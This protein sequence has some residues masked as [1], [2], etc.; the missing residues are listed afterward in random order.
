MSARAVRNAPEQPVLAYRVAT[1]DSLFAS[2][3]R[4]A[5]APAIPNTDV[6]NALH[7]LP[8][9]PEDGFVPA[10]F[11][12]WAVV[13]DVLTFYQE[14]IAN[15]GYLRTATEALSQRELVRMLSREPRPALSAT[16]VFAFSVA[17]AKGAPAETLVPA[18]TPIGA[19]PPPD[20]S[21]PPVFETHEALVA[22]GEWNA[23][24]PAFPPP[25][26]PALAGAGDAMRLAGDDLSV[27]KPGAPMIVRRRLASGDVDD[28]VVTVI[29]VV[30]D[31]VTKSAFVRWSPV[32]WSPPLEPTDAL[33]FVAFRTS[34]ALFGAKAPEWADLVP[35]IKARYFTPPGGVA[36]SPDGTAW[37]PAGSGAPKADVLALRIAG[38]RLYALTTAA[39]LRADGDAWT[40]LN[41]KARGDLSALAL[42]GD[43]IYAGS[44]R[45]EV[46]VSHDGGASWA[47]VAPAAATATAAALPAVKVHAL[48]VQ[49]PPGLVPVVFAATDRGVAAARDDGKGWSYFNAG[50]GGVTDDKATAPVAIT[51]IALRGTTLLVATSGALWTRDLATSG[52]GAGLPGPA[53]WTAR[54]VSGIPAGTTFAA[55]GF[56]DVYAFAATS[57]GLFRAGPDW[58]WSRVTDAAV[59]AA[60]SAVDAAGASVITTAAGGVAISRDRGTG[61]QTVAANPPVPATAVALA[62]DAQD[63]AYAVPLA[64]FPPD[65]PDMPLGGTGVDVERLVPSLATDAQV[66]LIDTAPATPVAQAARIVSAQTVRRKNFLQSGLVT[67]LELTALDPSAPLASF[68]RRTTRLY[69]DA[70]VL[71]AAPDPV[72]A[73]QPVLGATLTVDAATTPL[74]AGRLVAVYG[75]PIRAHVVGLAGGIRRIDATGAGTAWGLRGLDCRALAAAPDGTVYAGTSQ[76]VWRRPE[77]GDFA[78]WGFDAPPGP[79]PAMRAVAASAQVVVAAAAG[80][81]AGGSIY[82]R[83]TAGGDWSGPA[84]P[85][86]VAALLLGSDGTFWAGGAEGLSRS[87]DG[88][89]WRPVTEPGAPGRGDDGVQSL[90]WAPDG[91]TLLAGTTNGVAVRSADGTWAR[92]LRGLDNRDVTALAA[93]P[94][95]WWAGTNGG[96]VYTSADGGASWSPVP[97]AIQPGLHAVRALAFD[98]VLFAAVRGYGVLRDGVRVDAGIGND[99]RGLLVR[100]DGV[101]AAV[102]SGTVLASSAFVAQTISLRDLGAVEIGYTVDLE[103]GAIPAGLRSD[104]ATQLQLKLPA[105]ATVRTAG[106]GAWLLSADGA[107][108]LLLREAPAR[109]KIIVASVRSFVV[110][111]PAVPQPDGTAMWTVQH[112]DGTATFAARDGDVAYVAAGAADAFAGETVTV[113]STA[114]RR[115]TGIVEITF[116]QPLARVYDGATVQLFGN[117]ATGSHGMSG[118]TYEAIGNG[119]ASQANQAFTL[120]RRSLTMLEAADGTPQPQIAVVVRASIPR[121]A[122]ASA[123]DLRRDDTEAAGVPWTY[124][125]TLA[126]AGPGDRAYSVRFDDDVATVVFGDGTNGSRLPTGN[127]NVVAGYRTGNGPAGN[128]PADS[129]L[130]LRKR[131]GGLN[132]VRNPVDAAGGLAAE[133]PSD[134]VATAHAGLRTLE[135]I[136][137]LSDLEDFAVARTGIAQAKLR[138]A[139]GRRARAYL[140]IA[141][142]D[143]A[144]VADAAKQALLLAI[145]GAGGGAMPVVLHD[146]RRRYVRIAAALRID[147]GLDAAAI[148]AAADARVRDALAFESRALG[149]GLVAARVI[150][151][152]Q[153][154]PGVVAVTLSAFHD[155]AWSAFVAP[156]IAG[157]DAA[158]ASDGELLVLLD[159]DPSTLD[160]TVES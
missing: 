27:L 123:G 120:A 34:A 8:M 59:A 10:L 45:G 159:P 82:R 143:G 121:S 156:V 61:W 135:R 110:A 91:R 66:A 144:A 79:E 9:T 44:A 22:R 30:P 62:A 69:Y 83:A 103:R 94:S 88:A 60:P 102:R 56:G 29:D 139:G 67:H 141:G 90:A 12:A 51:G 20:G 38:G 47:A 149:E 32:R 157:E 64:D 19:S 1:Y 116:A 98:G 5:G 118:S 80:A 158:S 16:C 24:S 133:P 130:M 4:L 92:S 21:P 124:F 89:V 58:A 148:L 85:N 74:P 78:P 111:A 31:A 134:A 153:D 125:E 97:L 25:P 73:L 136:V 33:Q 147:A 71:G 122:I 128:I 76:G 127:E 104:L 49:A 87:A 54:P 106:A 13:G 93:G 108:D 152:L 140:T 53:P 114:V 11:D 50:L 145:R 146:P 28:T 15:E 151:L 46:F 107:D 113:A 101:L 150:E 95:A 52:A 81:T 109:V 84:G 41:P 132:G 70:R 129:T 55:V 137:S 96:G 68:G 77:G 65:W 42:A 115:A 57:A 17:T 155:A 6:P 138:L 37:S 105:G 100:R 119:D 117:C 26:L 3:Q 72:P 39:V 7:L 48:A 131:S 43:G 23:V 36:H 14:R 2:M 112:D 160:L 18:S 86:A 154:V 99:V 35:A 40:A 126:E 142:P 75:R 63:A